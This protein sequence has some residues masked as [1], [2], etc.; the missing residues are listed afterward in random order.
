MLFC[1]IITGG[2]GILV[3]LEDT[4]GSGKIVTN[5]YLEPTVKTT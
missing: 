1:S 3:G 5:T 2:I 4:G